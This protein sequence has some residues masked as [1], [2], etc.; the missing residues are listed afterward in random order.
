MI[1]KVRDFNT[2]IMQV[3]CAS[4][5]KIMDKH[6]KDFLYCDPPYYLSGDS[7]T[8]IGLYPH[9]NF[10]IYHNNFNH[11]QLRDFLYKHEGGFILSYNNC[12]T[13]REWYKGFKSIAPPWQYTLS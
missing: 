3:E 2:D 1:E 9:R 11:E 12:S 4:F 7:K 6:K 5:E 8:F 13:I 10:P